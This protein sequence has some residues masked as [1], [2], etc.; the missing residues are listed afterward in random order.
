MKKIKKLS[1]LVIFL[2]A[3][4]SFL[5]FKNSVWA[6][7]TFECIIRHS[8]VCM[9][10]GD[11]NKCSAGY[12]PGDCSVWRGKPQKCQTTHTCLPEDVADACTSKK[13]YIPCPTSY[14]AECTGKYQC[15]KTQEYCDQVAT[16]NYGCDPGTGNADDRITTALGC[17]PINNLNSFVGWLL[18]RLIFIA[19][20]IAFLLMAVGAFQILTSAGTPEKVKA[21]KELITSAL[22]GLIFII[23]SMFILKLIGVDI[24]HLPEFAN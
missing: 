16:I 22:T 21:G 4:L 13:F 17:I 3:F 19:S 12:K 9:E 15:C 18:G 23:L 14:P 8:G 24:L 5:S 10:K 2:M 7:G 20:G 6:Q 11:S 1:F